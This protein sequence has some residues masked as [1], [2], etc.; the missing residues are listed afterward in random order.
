MAKG[1]YIIFNNVP[2]QSVTAPPRRYGVMF[3]PNSSR[4]RLRIIDAGRRYAVRLA[5]DGTVE[6]SIDGETSWNPIDPLTDP[7]TG[8]QFPLFISHE[9]VRTGEPLNGVLF[10]MLAVGRGRII[11][12]EAGTDRLF[13]LYID[14]MFRTFLRECNPGEPGQTLDEDPPIPPFNMKIDP[15]YFTV[16]PPTMIVPPE[17]TRNYSNH[18]AS[19]RLPVFNQLLEVDVADV[20]LVLERARTWYLKDIRS[21][22]DIRAQEDFGFSEADLND[23]FSQPLL[24][25]ILEAIKNAGFELS[26]NPATDF[27]I[28][29]LADTEKLSHEWHDKLV[30]EGYAALIFPAYVALGILLWGGRESKAFKP[31]AGGEIRIDLPA[32][33]NFFANPTDNQAAAEFLNEAMSLLGDAV[34]QLMLRSRRAALERYGARPDVG[35]KELP[36]A[37]TLETRLPTP[38]QPPFWM[39]TYVRTTYVR[40]AGSWRGSWKIHYGPTDLL[41]WVWLGTN[42]DGRLEAFGLGPNDSVWHTVQLL[43]NGAWDGTWASSLGSVKR[44]KLAIARNQDGRLELFGFDPENRVWHISQLTPNG[45]WDTNWQELHSSTD[46]R[47]A[48]AAEMNDDGRLELFGISPDNRVWH[49]WQT[50]P[51]GRWHPKWEEIY[52]SGQTLRDVTLAR[53]LDGTLEAF[54]LSPDNRVWHTWQTTPGGGWNGSWNELYSMRDQRSKLA[55]GRHADG[56]LIVFAISPDE[57]VWTTEQSSPGVWSGGWSRFFSA[58]DKLRDIWVTTNI[59]GRLEVFG[60]STND[61]VWHTWQTA[62]KAGFNPG[63]QEITAAGGRTVLAV[64]PNV[65]GSI[66]IIGLSPVFFSDDRVWNLRMLSEKRF[67]IQFSEVLDIGIGASHWNENWQKQFGGE[68]HSLLAPRPLFQGERYSLT[69]YRFLNGPVIDGDAFNDGTTNY[70]MMVKLGT[71]ASDRAE[72]LQDYAIL[73]FDEQTYFTQRWRL[74]HPTDDVLGD[75][76]SLPHAMRDNPQWFNFKLATYWCPFREKN[77]IDDDSRMIVR[78]NIIVVTGFNHAL[79]R[80][81]IYTIV[82]NYGLCDHSW[83]WRLFPPAR[84]LLID[85]GV[86]QD[87][88]PPLPP[89]VRNGSE[90]AYVVVNTIDLRDDTTLHVRGSLRVGA[91]PALL[92]GRWVQRY[93]PADCRHVPERHELVGGRPAEGFA[94]TWDFISEPAYQR[95]DQFYQFGVYEHRLDSRGQYYEIELLPDS[96]GAIPPVADVVGRVWQNDKDGA[97]ADRLRHNTINFNWALP[98]ENGVIVKR[99][100]PEPDKPLA[101]ELFVHDFRER[102]SMSM[103]EPTTRFRILERKPLGLIAVFYDKRDDELQPASDLPQPT[104]FV[105]DFVEKTIPNHWKTEDGDTTVPVPDDTPGSI[106]V[107]VKSNRRVLQ[108]PNVRKAQILIDNAPGLRLLHI[109]FWTPQTEQEVCV[110]IWRVTLAAIDENGRV[111]SIFS[112]ERFGNFV[113]RAQPDAPV[114]SDFTGELGD[115]W[116]YDFTFNFESPDDRARETQVRRFCT[117]DGQIEFGTSLWFEDIVGHRSLAQELTFGV[118]VSDSE[119]FVVRNRP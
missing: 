96:T 86:A 61:R 8:Q 56:R 105:K 81:E 16:D 55:V 71:P 84:E 17:G 95:A 25:Q 4:S 26:D 57:T 11:G 85:R 14:E 10:D 29:L 66:E 45:A 43:P 108:P 109:S 27:L 99:M 103:Y 65:D 31:K 13:H 9:N 119:G 69:Q 35:R 23:V 112:E 98:R 28:W 75:L 76:F 30:E 40:R 87:Q 18:P 53:N 3:N 110:N 97:A 59:D 19:L 63:W 48:I 93:L 106:R 64:A 42:K 92:V 88:D 115:A 104:T 89:E 83:R 74:V 34:S 51:G 49:V 12:K 32:L 24:K 80:N 39:P 77:L 73:W 7:C 107:L 111:F 79:L 5:T 90:A 72:F 116:R 52:P 113:R 38:N 20:M 21:Q 58:E 78:R 46:R 2:F 62:P 100:T 70:Y 1:D 36:D 82:F 44:K 114:P 118:T 68:I 6:Y 33:K 67:A 47:N 101:P 50:V 117:A 54:G 22:L 102:D 91:P 41:H 15:E 94:H 60:V 37:W